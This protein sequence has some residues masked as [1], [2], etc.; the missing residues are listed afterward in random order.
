MLGRT[1]LAAFCLASSL[2]LGTARAQD[3]PRRVENVIIVTLD[4]FRH[5]ELF[6]GAERA[7][8]D[9]K[10]GGVEDVQATTKLY[11]RDTPEARRETLMPFLWRTIVGKGQVFGDRSKGATAAVT[12]GM[13]FS[14]PG[15]SE[16]FCGFGDPRV[17]S[18]DKVPN[19]NKTVLE[20]L[21]ELPAYRGKVAA[22][23]TWDVFPSIFRSSQNKLFVQAGWTPLEGEPQTE[24]QRQLNLMVRR[25][26]HYWGGNAFDFITMESTHVYVEKSR[27]RV[28]FIGLGETDEWAH[29]RRYDLYLQA[30]HESDD[31]LRSLWESLQAMPEYAG[32]TAMI[33][34]CD[35]GR[36]SNSDD[37][38]SHGEKV[39][40]AENIWIAVMGPTTPA[41]GIRTNVAVTQSQIASTIAALLGED[42]LAASPRSAQPL[43]GVGVAVAQNGAS[44]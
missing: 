34:T 26:P 14:Y 39:D 16:I 41:L 3:A 8:I 29:H 27:P 13:K 17:D 43:P 33:V 23:C 18:N 24:R 44:R 42:F 31:F 9:A 19:P 4:G 1:F 11:W 32:K 7:L 38:T 37:W 40:G 22:V 15:Y 10:A 2:P 20:F 28:L 12:N 5:Q 30:A 21:D 35:H 25:L 36:G 6:G